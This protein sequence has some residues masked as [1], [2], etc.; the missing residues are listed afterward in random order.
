MERE[1]L[2][3]QRQRLFELQSI[4]LVARLEVELLEDGGNRDE[5]LLPGERAAL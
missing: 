3:L 4:C 5:S 1:V 2:G